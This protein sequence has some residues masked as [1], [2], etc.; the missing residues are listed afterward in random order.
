MYEILVT[1]WEFFVSEIQE[2]IVEPGKIITT[3]GIS[4]DIDM[5]LTLAAKISMVALFE[6]I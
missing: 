4:T 1:T 2:K 6:K 3:A 5:A